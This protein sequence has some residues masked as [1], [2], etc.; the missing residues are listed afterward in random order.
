[1][2]IEQRETAEKLWERRLR[3]EEMLSDLSVRFMTAPFDQVDSEIDNT[4]RKIVDF[5]QVDLCGLLEVQEDRAF[6]RA[7]HVVYG[8][9]IE[10]ITGDINLVEWYPWTYG[11]M[12]RGEHVSIN[13]LEDYPEDA[14]I[15]RQSNAAMG[16]T[17]RL[18][19]PVFLGGRISR[20]ITIHQR[21]RH[22]TWPEEYIPRLRQMGEILVNAMERRRVSLQLEEQLRFE[23]L[24]LEISGRFI[25]LPADQIDSEIEDAQRRVSEF[26]G[27]D[28]SALWQWSMETS[29]IVIPTHL[30]RPAGSPPLPEPMFTHEDFPWSLK[31]MEA[32]RTIVVSSIDE[33]PAEAARDL[34]MCRRLGIKSNLTIPLSVGGG[35]PIG[36][37]GFNTIRAKRDWPDALVKQLQ[38]VA[39]IFTNALA[40]K[41]ADQ[42][43]RESEARLSMATE[44][45][46]VG[47]W[48]MDVDKGGIWVSPKSREL[49]HFAQDEEIHYESYFRVIH[50]DDRERINQEVQQALRSGKRLVCDYRII[51]PDGTIRWI[52]TRGQRFLKSTGEPERMM[53]VSLDITER[54][55]MENQLQEQLAE[56]NKLKFQLE[57]ENLYLREEIKAERGFD[58]IIGDSDALQYVLFRAQ[59]VASTDATVLIL[60]ETGTGK[61]MVAHAIHEMSTRKDK[62]MITINCAALPANL[63]ESELF[64]REKGAF[65]GAHARQVGRFE[66]ANGG[67][68]FLDEIGEIPVELQ[69]KLLRVLQDGEFERLGS[70]KTIKVDVRVIAATSRDLKAE[71]RNGRFREDLFYR[72]NVFPVTIP[73]LRMRTEDISELTRHFID[74]YAQKA[75]S[76]LKPLRKK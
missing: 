9:G 50:P 15:D 74:K 32:G 38:L 49:F 10:P 16:T 45:V 7:S 43:L 39:Q 48:I 46:E 27:L 68:L 71:V 75:G 33:L 42:A 69:A 13:R 40:R 51:R 18:V 29:R 5:F 30:Y 22:Q 64:G 67:T 1:M 4:L 60:G 44:A 25:Y 73:P 63:I 11:K 20:I 24:L 12:I 31:Q 21:L 35:P 34:E 56:I 76:D 28:F 62:P 3:F 65:T 6:V 55:K 37:L 26:L 59:Q 19:I 66:V 72:L 54:K 70:P 23:M 52:A 17:S 57:E 53:G 41:R 61:G 14:L 58:K 2:L 8:E 47:L 36:I